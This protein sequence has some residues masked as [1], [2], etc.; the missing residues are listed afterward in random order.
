M[1]FSTSPEEI[2]VEI[3]S[4]LSD[5]IS[6]L[7]SYTLISHFLHSIAFQL[8]FAV[9]EFYPSYRY[10]RNI[11]PPQFESFYKVLQESPCAESLASAVKVLKISNVERPPFYV[12]DGD[13]YPNW[14]SKEP[15]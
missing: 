3:L 11:P 13:V 8:L 15:D 5:D 14:V 12:T 1:S 2:V 4:H 7:K 10:Q 9:V 6:S